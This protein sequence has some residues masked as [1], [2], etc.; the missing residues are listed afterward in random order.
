MDD[1]EKYCTCCN[2]DLTDKGIVM[3]E[4][5]Q[6]TNTYHDFGN[7]PPDCS[8]GWFE[9]GATCAKKMRRK[10]RAASKGAA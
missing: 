7:V 3:L 2:R 5:D 10:A 9:F 1:E 4:L 6:R 8:Q